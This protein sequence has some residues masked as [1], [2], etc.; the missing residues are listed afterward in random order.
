MLF[1]RGPTRSIVEW[2]RLEPWNGV[3]AIDMDRRASDPE[4]G[5]RGYRRPCP[6]Y[7]G[8]LARISIKWLVA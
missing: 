3:V 1:Q 6:P 2:G 7:K 8:L 5:S 4:A